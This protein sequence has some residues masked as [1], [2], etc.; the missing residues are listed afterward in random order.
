MQAGLSLLVGVKQ[1]FRFHRLLSKNFRVR[2]DLG[3]LTTLLFLEREKQRPRELRGFAMDPTAGWRKTG[4]KPNPRTP[5]FRCYFLSQ[6]L[7][8]GIYFPSLLAHTNEC[9]HTHT[10]TH[11]HTRTH[12][13]G[14]ENY[15]CLVCSP[16]AVRVIGNNCLQPTF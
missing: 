16:A 1:S 2:R 13:L 5:E 7:K 11:T 3:Q 10:H 8:P 6:A 12:D 9:R 14:R 4:R 15:N